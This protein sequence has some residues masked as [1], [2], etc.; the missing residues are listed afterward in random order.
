MWELLSRKRQAGVIILLAIYLAWIFNVIADWWVGTPTPITHMASWVTLA[1]GTR[2]VI[3][4]GAAW[5]RIWRWLPWLDRNV[6]PD[7]TG[8]WRGT[9]SSTWV[10]PASSQI[11]PLIS[12]TFEI[13]QRI[14]TTSIRMRTTESSSHSLR[15][16]LEADR[17]SGRFRL[18]Y[19]YQ[20]DP[21]QGVRD[22][23]AR[24]D[25]VC[26]FEIDPSAKPRRITGSYY[27]DRKTSGDIEIER[28]SDSF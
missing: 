21:K 24:H 12:V 23:S 5:R 14:L 4:A 25:G 22:R 11:Q 27:T 19:V 15:S 1:I 3:S 9:L 7:C 28:V 18:G 10:N 26:W 2:L 20:N 16:W 13:R 6:F 8:I 17:D